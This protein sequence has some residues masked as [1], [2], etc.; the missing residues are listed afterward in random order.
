MPNATT[1]ASSAFAKGQLFR[2]LK[3]QFKPTLTFAEED[4][5]EVILSYRTDL[6]H[7]SGDKKAR[8]SL[9]AAPCAPVL[10]LPQR[11][12]HTPL[13]I[14]GVLLWAD[15]NGGAGAFWPFGCQGLYICEALA[16]A[17]KDNGVRPFHGRMVKGG[18][19]W[20]QA[21]YAP[22]ET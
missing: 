15:M 2:V 8:E 17:F 18:E 4:D 10:P 12:A 5:V 3:A 1:A 20:Q 19:N 7:N 6:V 21:W 13:V 16:K 22:C 11:K 9:A 14:C